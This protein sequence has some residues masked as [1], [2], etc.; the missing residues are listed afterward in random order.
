MLQQA[1]GERLLDRHRRGRPGRRLEQGPDPGHLRQEQHG[2]RVGRPHPDPHRYGPPPSARVNTARTATQPHLV[3]MASKA[4]TVLDAQT[5]HSKKGFFLQIEGASIDKQDHAANPCGQIGETVAFDAAI[6]QVPRLPE[7]APG[8]PGGRDR[9]PRATPARSSRPRTL[10]VHRHGDHPRQR[11]HDDQLRHLRRSPV[12]SS[13]PAPR[14]G[15]AAVGPQAAN[16][17][18]RDQPD[19][20]VLHDEAGPGPQVRIFKASAGAAIRCPARVCL[21]AGRDRAADHRVPPVVQRDHLVAAARRTGPARHRR[22]SRRA[23]VSSVS[24]RNASSG[25]VG[26]SRP[27]L[28]A[29]HRAADQPGGAVRV[30]AGAAAG[31]Q[32]GRA[33]PPRRPGRARPR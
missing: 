28:K 12:R 29:R 23:G 32:A 9:R 11:H 22:S 6:K 15:I 7:V 20:P 24:L 33:G 14:C 19:R 17:L 13:T 26:G 10:G 4:L 21:Q 8:H 2:C 25:Q 5:K 1:Q 16:V 30:P 31:D 27:G 18:G 3:D